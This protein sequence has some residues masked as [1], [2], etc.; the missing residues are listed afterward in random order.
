MTELK[1]KPRYYSSSIINFIIFLILAIAIYC[2]WTNAYNERLTDIDKYHAWLIDRV[3]R[4]SMRQLVYPFLF[5]PFIAFIYW[6][7]E[8]DKKYRYLI[9]IITSI[10]WFLIYVFASDW[11]EHIWEIISLSAF[12]PTWIPSFIAALIWVWIVRIITTIIKAV[13]SK[14][15]K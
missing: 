14:N 4:D 12:V 1:K 7:L 5:I 13:K 2:H 15:K 8:W 11:W 9:P 10:T 6:L 3:E